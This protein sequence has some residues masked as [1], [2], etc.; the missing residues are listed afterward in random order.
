M[1]RPRKRNDLPPFAT[2]HSTEFGLIQV[3]INYLFDFELTL[4]NSLIKQY[5][6]ILKLK[7]ILTKYKQERENAGT[8]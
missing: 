8:I 2:Y 4:I 5:R 1:K 7:F 6:H 3:M